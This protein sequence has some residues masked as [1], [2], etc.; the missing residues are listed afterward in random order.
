MGEE[1]LLEIDL[2]LRLQGNLV[3]CGAQVNITISA[4]VSSKEESAR[5]LPALPVMWF[6]EGHVSGSCLYCTSSRSCGQSGEFTS[7]G[8][9]SGR[10]RFIFSVVSLSDEHLCSVVEGLHFLPFVRL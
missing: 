3:P 10:D 1:G 9:D 4:F 7:L 2:I 5:V 8:V 6:A